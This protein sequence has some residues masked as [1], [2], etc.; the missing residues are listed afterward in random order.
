MNRVNNNNN[1]NT[2]RIVFKDSREELSMVT[3]E[4]EVQVD[5]DL[6]L[7][8]LSR[9]AT[10]TSRTA[11]L[12]IVDLAP[13]TSLIARPNT[14]HHVI[15]TV[16]NNHRLTLYHTFTPKS[17]AFRIYN[18]VPQIQ[19]IRAGE[20]IKVGVLINIPNVN[21][22]IANAVTL[23]VERGNIDNPIQKSAYIYVQSP[24]NRVS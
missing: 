23:E 7:D 15:F 22:N 16:T 9:A 20:T 18:V 10:V 12:L 4:G 13:E 11:R 1:N 19:W 5:D 8:E 6:E 3:V 2:G 24:E 14:I 21:Y 17:S